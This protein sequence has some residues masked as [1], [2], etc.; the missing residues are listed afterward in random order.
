MNAL[1]GIKNE[2]YTSIQ[3]LLLVLSLAML[4]GV[5]G[6]LIG[7][8]SFALMAVGGVVLLYLIHPMVSPQFI[9]RLQ[10]ARRLH[11]HE[12]PQLFARL[13]ALAER[14]RLP[15]PP[16][17]YYV[18]A[19]AM[20][21]FSV[22]NRESAAIALTDGLLRRLDIP[23]ITGVLAH[24]ISHLRHNDLRIMGFAGLTRQLIHMLSLLGQILL[25]LNLPLLLWGH[26]SISWAAILLLIFAPTIS[27]ILQLALSRTREYRADLG[28]AKL[29]EDGRPLASAL[30][31]METYH[32]GFLR[33]IL[34]PGHRQT[35]EGAL[36]RTHPHTRKRIRRL[37]ENQVYRSHDN[38]HPAVPSKPGYPPGAPMRFP[39]RL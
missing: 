35:T 3:S 18:P 29:M 5:M 20:N 16:M 28:A 4:L 25:F 22:G 26:Y 15:R 36:L 33:G 27:A 12:A 11:E 39:V 23:E 10:K 34:W 9:L 2:V 19:E 32:H 7:G 21:A 17:L 6:W 13:R 30:A 38:H 31:K 1:N 24:E 8:Q 14:A 37:L